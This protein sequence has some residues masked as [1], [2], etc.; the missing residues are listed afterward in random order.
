MKMQTVKVNPTK[1]VHEYNLP[2]T[3]LYI[4]TTGW[5]LQWENRRLPYL[6]KGWPPATQIR[7]IEKAG[8]ISI[9]H[10]G[11]TTER[12]LPKSIILAIADAT[13]EEA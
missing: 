11:E 8:L 6:H 12:W 2:T 7:D 1:T 3:K 10:Y 4:I 9:N 5:T 13:T